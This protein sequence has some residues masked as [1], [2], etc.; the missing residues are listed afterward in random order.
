[1]RRSRTGYVLL[2]VVTG[3][4]LLAVLLTVSLKM[5]ATMS[6][7]RAAIE[8]RAVA[9]QL[10]AGAIERAAALPW[11]QITTE[12]WT[13]SPKNQAVPRFCRARY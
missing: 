13:R 7:G 2:D 9:L 6:S 1:M 4:A 12:R 10:V 3:T 11:D 5:F 8:N